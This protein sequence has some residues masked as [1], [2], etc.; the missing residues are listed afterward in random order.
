MMMFNFH[1]QVK[2][3]GAVAVRCSD[4]VRLSHGHGCLFSDFNDSIIV[5][6]LLE[7]GDIV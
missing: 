4:F 6:N 5:P 1:V 7:S 3:E 2:T